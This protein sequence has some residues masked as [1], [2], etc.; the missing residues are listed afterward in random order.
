MQR[1]MLAAKGAGKR[2]GV[3]PTM[4]FLH[5]GH[6]SLIRTARTTSDVVI[7]TIFVNPLQF[8]PTEDLTRYPRNLERD[9]ELAKQ[10]GADYLFTPLPEEIYPPDFDLTVSVG[11]VSAPF[12]GVSRP[13]HFAGVATV[14]AKLLLITQADAAFFGQKDYQQTLVV[15]KLIRDLAMPVELVVCPT[16]RE[17]DGLAMSSRNV[18]LSPEDRTKASVL[19]RSLQ[20]AEMLIRAGE[21]RRSAL[22][23]RLREMLLAETILAIDYAAA[24]DAE[25]LAQ[26]ETFTPEQAI[27]LLLAVRIGSTRLIDNLVVR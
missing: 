22:E 10:A 14:V 16:S 17:A 26:P 25:T 2:V 5:D 12:E 8:A 23:Q 6:A 9:T 27:V 24:A 15:G 19:H 1:T 4:G 21:R 7:V 11:G 18:Y 3:V 20:G 13:T